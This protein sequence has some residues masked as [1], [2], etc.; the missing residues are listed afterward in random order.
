MSKVTILGAGNIGRA[1]AKYLNELGYHVDICDNSQES[2]DLCQIDNILT[3]KVLLGEH[4][5]WQDVA[6]NV[7]LSC[8]PYHQNFEVAKFCIDTNRKYVDLGGSVEVTN[9]IEKYYSNANWETSGTI[10]LN[11]GL[12][13]GYVNCLLWKALSRFQG[14]VDSIL[15][16]VGGLPNNRGS[17]WDDLGPLKYTLTWSVDGLINEYKADCE[18][19]KNGKITTVKGLSGYE[20]IDDDFEMFRTSGGIAETV[21]EM[22]S[23]GVKNCEYK[24]IRYAGHHKIVNFLINHAE[25][26]DEKLKEIFVKNC[27][28]ISDMVFIKLYVKQGPVVYGTWDQISSDYDTSAMQK[29]TA[30]PASVV[31]DLVAKGV[32]KN[33]VKPEYIAEIPEFWTKVKELGL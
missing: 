29:S 18:I 6:S 27:P 30:I 17:W 28:K 12:A 25:L 23:M 20:R 11:Q 9:Q 10:A 1:C 8:L 13:P 5:R 19:L 24:T 32:L 33:R 26:S 31:V 16:A 21:K 4:A 3:N 14:P 22:Y 15:M 2:L 7:I